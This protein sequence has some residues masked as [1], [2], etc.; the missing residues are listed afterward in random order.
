MSHIRHLVFK[1]TFTPSIWIILIIPV[2][3]VVVLIRSIVISPSASLIIPIILCSL[4]LILLPFELGLLAGHLFRLFL[5]VFLL[6][7]NALLL[8]VLD[9]L[10]RRQVPHRVVRHDPHIVHERVVHRPH[11]N[12]VDL[13]CFCEVD[14]VDGADL[15]DVCG[16]HLD[17]QIANYLALLAI[18]FDLRKV[19][20]I[21]V[22]HD[23]PKVDHAVLAGCDHAILSPID[24]RIAYV[25]SRIS[26]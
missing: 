10:V 22:S 23:V 11:Y 16:V 2:V 26:P 21:V 14:L 6:L 1:S 18:L 17:E 15:G 5:G 20:T 7:Q 12:G 19:C 4:A 3:T 13:G 8:R 9:V 24:M 25:P